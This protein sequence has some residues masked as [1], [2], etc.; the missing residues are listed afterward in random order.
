MDIKWP[1]RFIDNLFHF[2]RTRVAA[3]CFICHYITE[4]MFL[5]GLAMAGAGALIRIT[6]FNAMINPLL[7]I[8]FGPS[9]TKCIAFCYYTGNEMEAAVA[10]AAATSMHSEWVF[11]KC[12][13][14]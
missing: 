13:A 1:F 7:P 11:A 14:A 5:Y 8:L 2:V 3:V 9:S 6:M 12:N 4:L 10:D